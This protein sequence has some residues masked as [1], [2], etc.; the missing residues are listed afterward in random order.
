MQAQLKRDEIAARERV[1]MAKLA[2]KEQDRQMEFEKEAL[3]AEQLDA[4]ARL[5]MTLGSGL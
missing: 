2:D 3:R 1:E 5:K 4:E